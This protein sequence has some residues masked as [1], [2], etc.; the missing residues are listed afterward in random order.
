[1]AVECV[2]KNAAKSCGEGPHWDEATNALL[3]VDA[4]EK[5]IHRYQPGTKT[6]EG[7]YTGNLTFNYFF[8]KFKNFKM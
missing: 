4:V 8:K 6:D 7:F 3:Y 2:V 1:M 5:S